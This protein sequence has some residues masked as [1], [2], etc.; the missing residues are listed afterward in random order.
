MKALSCPVLSMHRPH[1]W[2]YVSGHIE[3]VQPEGESVTTPTYADYQCPGVK[4]S[5][6]TSPP[7]AYIAAPA[8]LESP[9]GGRTGALDKGFDVKHLAEVASFTPLKP[10]SS[11]WGA[12]V[13][14]DLSGLAKDIAEDDEP[15]VH[16]SGVLKDAAILIRRARDVVDL[17]VETTGERG[18]SVCAE[19]TRINRYGQEAHPCATRRL[20]GLL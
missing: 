6:A 3:V 11:N 15:L 12:R 1:T 16:A 20:L 19:C 13:L 4:V 8:V 7:N 10:G 18:A 14:E 17:H 5:W 9:A 2:E